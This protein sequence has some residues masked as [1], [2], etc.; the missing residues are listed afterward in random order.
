MVLIS[1]INQTGAISAL[2]YAV[3]KGL[4]YICTKPDS[5]SQELTDQFRE[6]MADLKESSEALLGG[7]TWFVLTDIIADNGWISF[8]FFK[9]LTY[10]RKESSFGNLDNCLQT[11]ASLASFCVAAWAI[12]LGIFKMSPCAGNFFATRS[13]H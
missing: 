3:P 11:T 13:Y 8:L 12:R 1:S 5:S 2:L 9:Y 4:T 6:K 7:K 10:E